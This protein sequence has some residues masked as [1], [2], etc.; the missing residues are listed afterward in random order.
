MVLFPEV[1]T[2]RAI[3]GYIL[4]VVSAFTVAGTLFRLLEP[5]R[6]GG[7]IARF[8]A[9]F[10]IIGSF[11]FTLTAV[12]AIVAGPY[13]FAGPT[14]TGGYI[15]DPLTFRETVF[16]GIALGL[17]GALM[18]PIVGRSKNSDIDM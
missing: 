12:M 5:L 6:R 17:L 18:W 8:L 2:S 7:T 13:I 11:Y 16:M 10:W 4:G 1:K 15:S 9:R 3:I 14:R